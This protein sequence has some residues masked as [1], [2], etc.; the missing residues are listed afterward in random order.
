[1]EEELSVPPGHGS[2]LLHAVA[3]LPV[4]GKEL[5][6]LILILLSCQVPLPQQIRSICSPFVPVT[7]NGFHLNW[8]LRADVGR[9]GVCQ[10][11]QVQGGGAKSCAVN[12]E[13]SREQQDL[14]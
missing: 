8:V 2:A 11:T 1:M 9:A 3:S 7:L 6:P 12:R 10:H 14:P 13:R 4:V 5:K